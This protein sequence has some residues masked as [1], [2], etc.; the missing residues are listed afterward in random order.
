ML[1]ST[2]CAVRPVMREYEI[3]V[4]GEHDSDIAVYK[5]FLS[6]VTLAIGEG[7]RI[8]AAG[9]FEVW[10]GMDCIFS[11]HPNQGWSSPFDISTDLSASEGGV[12]M[13]GSESCASR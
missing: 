4:F 9:P 6:S 11:T 8:A 7:R 12:S 3:R 1:E 10:L 2:D 13:Q 5:T